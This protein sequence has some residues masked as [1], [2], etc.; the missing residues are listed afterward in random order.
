MENNVGNAG[1]DNLPSVKNGDQQC[2]SLANVN[3]LDVGQAEAAKALILNL[4]KGKKNG[5]STVEEGLALLVK[6]Q[7]LNLPFTTACE[8]VY[9][10]PNGKTGID[11]HLTKSLLL[12]A[13]VTW[14]CIDNY[15]PLYK[16]TDGSNIYNDGD[17]PPYAVRCRSEKE[18]EEKTN[19]EQI[20][21]YPLKYYSDLNGNILNQFEINEKCVICINRMA[22]QKVVKEGKYPVI[23]TQLLPY[24]RVVRYKFTRYIKTLGGVKELHSIGSFSQLDAQQA[25]LIK[26]GGTYSK[27]PKVMIA[28]RAFTYGARDI[29]SD[30][31]S[32]L[33]ETTELKIINNEPITD[34]DIDNIQEAQVVE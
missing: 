4:V 25:G 1:S 14:E 29:A 16:Y 27:Y 31:L 10:G 6:A 9:I 5:I 21:V 18:A 24:D 8:H 17:L 33:Y 32:G 30:V 19:D 2:N 28:I 20:G 34:A 7:E 13:G 11:I 22:A 15:T 12:K 3:L 23:R 26:D